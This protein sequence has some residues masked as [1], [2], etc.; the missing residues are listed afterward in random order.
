MRR[1]TLT[2]ARRRL[3]W[4]RRNCWI[5]TLFLFSL[6]TKRILIALYNYGW[7][8][9][10]FTN[11]L[12]TVLGLEHVSCIAVYAESESSQIS[13]KISSFVFWRWTKVLRIWKDKRVSNSL[14]NFHFCANYHL[15]MYPSS[16]SMLM[17]TFSAW[18]EN[19][20]YLFFKC[21]L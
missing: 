6:H 7:T 3:T 20:R 12:T 17:E 15:K 19:S 14:H 10:Y 11:I 5:K 9:D 4:K 13:S 21:K 1:D 18:N 8:P 16:C 2:N